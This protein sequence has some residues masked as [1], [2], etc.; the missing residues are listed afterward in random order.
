MNKERKSGRNWRQLGEL[1][2]SCAMAQEFTN[3]HSP[4]IMM[5][6]PN[7]QPAL[8]FNIESVFVYSTYVRLK[9]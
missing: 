9:D 2:A 4:K 7:A 3:N 5:I 1:R 6:I 8:R